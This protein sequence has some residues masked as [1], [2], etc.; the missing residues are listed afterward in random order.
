[1]ETEGFIIAAQDQTLVNQ[2]LSDKDYINGLDP[3]VYY[4]NEKL[5]QWMSSCLIQTPIEYKEQ[6]NK[7]EH[8]IHWKIYK[9]YGIL[10]LNND[11]NTNQN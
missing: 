1:M 8:S 9:Y 7:T 4:E 3:Y 11:I 6:H 5:N 2:K 10:K